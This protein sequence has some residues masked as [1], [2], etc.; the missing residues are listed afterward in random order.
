MSIL[1]I[2]IL[3]MNVKRKKTDYVI[4]ALASALITTCYR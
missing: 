2:K 3:V 4:E 1:Y